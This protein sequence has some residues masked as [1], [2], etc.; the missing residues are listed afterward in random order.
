MQAVESPGW[1]GIWRRAP[2]ARNRE[3]NRSARNGSIEITTPIARFAADDDHFAPGNR[4]S[5]FQTP[6]L[7]FWTRFCNWRRSYCAL[8][9]PGHFIPGLLASINFR[10]AARR[11]R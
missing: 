1:R 10:T 4:P 6:V 8:R 9:R 5:A 7:D 11:D 3:V 2:V